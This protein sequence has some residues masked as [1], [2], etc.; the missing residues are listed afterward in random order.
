MV[1]WTIVYRLRFCRAYERCGYAKD[2]DREKADS[3][4]SGNRRAKADGKMHLD[5]H[6]RLLNQHMGAIRAFGFSRFQVAT[7]IAEILPHLSDRA[8]D[9]S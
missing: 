5:I 4:R 9:D 2:K 7:L 3:A 6:A 8:L 1:L